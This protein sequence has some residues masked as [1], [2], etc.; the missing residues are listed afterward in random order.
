MRD[1]AYEKEIKKEQV[2]CKFCNWIGLLCEFEEHFKQHHSE[3]TLDFNLNA[4]TK[5]LYYDLAYLE[6]VMQCL[7]SKSK[8]IDNNTVFNSRLE[9][10]EL[11]QKILSNCLNKYIANYDHL[12]DE[13][14]KSKDNIKRYEQEL[15]YMQVKLFDLQNKSQLLQ[16]THETIITNGT[17]K[18]KIKNINGVLSTDTIYSSSFLTSHNGYKM[19]ARLRFIKNNPNYGN[20]LSLESVIMK[21]EFD[22]MLRWPFNQTVTFMLLDQSEND[23]K[24]NLI[25]NCEAVSLARPTSYLGSACGISKLCSL[26]EIVKEDSIYVKDNCMF[27]KIIVG[28]RNLIDI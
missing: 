20:C 24:N 22:Q 16:I 13:L 10:F 14:I 15:E 18:W 9:N 25:G 1:K 26:Y 7:K 27:I 12:N 21:G 11:N 28:H 23:I 17:Y 6:N 4:V 19:C 8:I 3:D 5:K 2:T